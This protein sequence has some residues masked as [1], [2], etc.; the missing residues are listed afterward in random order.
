MYVFPYL[1][2]RTHHTFTVILCMV[3]TYV[4]ISSLLYKP[5]HMSLLYVRSSLYRAQ[6]RYSLC[7]THAVVVI[8]WSS[9]VWYLCYCRSYGL[10]RMVRY[11]TYCKVRWVMYLIY[12]TYVCVYFHCRTPVVFAVPVPYVRT[13]TYG[14]CHTYSGLTYGTY[15]TYVFITLPYPCRYIRYGIQVR[16]YVRTYDLHGKRCKL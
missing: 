8:V 13:C 9:Q 7:H 4:S 15:S 1:L 3:R 16:T 10:C 14:L 6:D 12:G 2:R 11:R 5:Y